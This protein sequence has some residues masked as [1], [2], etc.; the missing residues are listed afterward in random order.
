MWSSLSKFHLSVGLKQ[1]S[2][3]AH[4][5]SN[6]VNNIFM[7]PMLTLGSSLEM[8]TFGFSQQI[9]LLFQ[10]TIVDTL[11]QSTMLTPG[12]SPQCGHSVPVNNVNTLF[13]STMQCGH[14]IPVHNSVIL[15]RSTN[16]NTLIQ[17]TNVDTV[18]V[19]KYEH[20]VPVHRLPVSAQLLTR[21]HW[22]C[23]PPSHFTGCKNTTVLHFTL[24][25]SCLPT[26]SQLKAREGQK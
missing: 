19:H 4:F 8:W 25:A 26:K 23:W 12:C 1:P 9:L 22:N 2:E 20:S 16:V 6:N 14:Y 7:S 15:F 13:Q 5:Y 21:L 11:F 3:D 10:S 24:E 17:S 18:P